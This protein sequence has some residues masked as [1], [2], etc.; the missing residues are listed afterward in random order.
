VPP[1]ERTPRDQARAQIQE[2][3]RITAAAVGELRSQQVRDTYASLSLEEL[4]DLHIAQLTDSDDPNRPSRKQRIEKVYNDF[5]NNI[6]A[7]KQAPP[8]Q[9]RRHDSATDANTDPS[10]ADDS[11]S[12][13]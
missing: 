3:R 8:D 9:F 2:F 4:I 5:S 12:S 1:D 13:P 6:E 7:L 11:G 10:G